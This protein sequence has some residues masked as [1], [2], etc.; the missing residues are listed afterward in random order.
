MIS[1]FFVSLTVKAGLQSFVPLSIILGNAVVFVLM[2]YKM[3]KIYNINFPFKNTMSILLLSTPFVLIVV[4]RESFKAL[5]ETLF[6]L[7]IA[8][9]YFLIVAYNIFIRKNYK[10][11]N[12]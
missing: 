2:I 9:S 10:R 7:V 11:L 3:R 4:N 8:T 12:N 5:P 6:V 1:L